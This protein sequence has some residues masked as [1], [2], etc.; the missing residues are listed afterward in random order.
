[1]MQRETATALPVELALTPDELKVPASALYISPNV[2]MVAAGMAS[3]V[4]VPA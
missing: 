4:K 3:G 2:F 1:M